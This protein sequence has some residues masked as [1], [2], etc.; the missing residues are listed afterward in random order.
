MI[1]FVLSLFR[2]A[3]LF[4]N[5]YRSLVLENIALRQQLAVYKRKQRLPELTARDRWLWMILAR[6]WKGWRKSLFIVHPDTVVRWQRDRF[7]KFWASLSGRSPGRP[8]ISREI[9]ELVHRMI[10]ANPL[11]RAPR[12]HGELKK[13]GIKIS[14][15]TVSRILRLIP[16]PP[17]Q[18]W[19]TFLRNHAREIV[20]TDFF[21]V[22]TANLRVMFVFLVLV[23][24][25]RRVLHF[26]ITEHPTSGWVAQQIMEAFADRDATRYLIRDRDGAYG[27]EFR[28]CIQS[29]GTQVVLTAPGSPW[30]NAIVERL[31][32]SIR[33]ECLDHVVVLNRRHLHRLLKSYLAYYH[34]TRTHLALDKDSP[35]PREVM[36]QGKIVALP[37]VGGLHH[38]YERLAA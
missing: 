11:W 6:V 35:E 38:R 31:I 27:E 22:P 33:R 5:P 15:R 25:R 16:R 9:R 24:D 14:E 4:G 29:L 8:P 13:L 19:K 30:Q 28:Q 23:H 18:T 32:G 17:S 36:N 37:Q 34:Q 21:T 12:I 1:A 7:R 20:S 2:E 10:L 26:G 3:F